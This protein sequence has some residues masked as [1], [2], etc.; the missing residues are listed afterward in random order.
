MI[1]IAFRLRQ[2]VYL[3]FNPCVYSFSWYF[4]VPSFKIRYYLFHP[5]TVS[6]TEGDI[7]HCRDC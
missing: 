1:C 3:I 4:Y 6:V 2:S 7:Y 5:H